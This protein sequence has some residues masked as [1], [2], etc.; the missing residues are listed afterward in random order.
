MRLRR[1]CVQI[2]REKLAWAAGFFDGEGHASIS[3]KGNGAKFYL[4]VS[5][6]DLKILERFQDAVGGIGHINGPH[7]YYGTKDIWRWSATSFEDAQAV[8]L[9]LLSFLSDYKTT[10]IMNGLTF[11]RQWFDIVIEQRRFCK[12]GHLRTL[13][14]TYVVPRTGKKQCME[15]RG[16]QSGRISNEPTMSRT[17]M[18]SGGG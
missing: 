9:M 11:M 10:Q 6:T 2:N 12:K 7:N 17:R 18:F 16:L 15:C 5:Q 8:S 14:N 3:R 13:D 1:S 4:A